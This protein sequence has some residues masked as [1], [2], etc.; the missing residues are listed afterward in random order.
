MFASTTR[1]LR[2][3]VLLLPILGL[4]LG[5]AAPADAGVVARVSLS[6]QRMDVFVDGR[7]M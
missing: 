7:P 6:S 3:C 1:T 5:F 2:R 4:M